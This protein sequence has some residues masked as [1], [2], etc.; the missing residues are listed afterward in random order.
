M[1]AETSA[2]QKYASLSGSVRNV[3]S[4]AC[5]HCG[6]SITWHSDGLQ[7]HGQCQPCTKA[8]RGPLGHSPRIEAVYILKD[9][10]YLNARGV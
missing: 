3:C 9:G 8:L 7:W 1:Q 2:P 5:P 4:T 6:T 10:C